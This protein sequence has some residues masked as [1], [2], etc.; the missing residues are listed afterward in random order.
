M[1]RAAVSVEGVR[2]WGEGRGSSRCNHEKNAGGPGLQ[3]V[4]VVIATLR[5]CDA[6]AGPTE[7]VP[8]FQE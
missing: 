3:H 4:R 1:D 8:Q 2:S 7:P 6:P 5:P